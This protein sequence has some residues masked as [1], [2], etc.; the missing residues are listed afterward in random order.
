MFA[1]PIHDSTAHCFRLSLPEGEVR[2]DYRSLSPGWVDFHHTYTPVT[3]RGRGLAAQVV[4]AGLDWAEAEG[5]R[6]VAS[7][8]Y[9]AA[10]LAQRGSRERS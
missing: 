6:V 3:L 8:S 9:V 2:L 4:A 1:V 10:A 5:L 7:C